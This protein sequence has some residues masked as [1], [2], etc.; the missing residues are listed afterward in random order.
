MTGEL[1]KLFKGNVVEVIKPNQEKYWGFLHEAIDGSYWR[2][3]NHER[4]I[5]F[6]EEEV[7]KI[8]FRSETFNQISAAYSSIEILLCDPKSEDSESY[9][10]YSYEDSPVTKVLKK[11]YRSLLGHN[12]KTFEGKR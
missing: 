3:A 7:Q 10:A 9:P 12:V 5:S 8:S 2:V 11:A 1:L 6:K 4:A